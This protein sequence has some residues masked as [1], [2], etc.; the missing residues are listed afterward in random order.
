MIKQLLGH[1][2][3]FFQILLL[4]FSKKS[5]TIKHH[6]VSTRRD[7][8]S[9]FYVKFVPLLNKSLIFFV[10]I[11]LLVNQQQK[12]PLFFNCSLH[13]LKWGSNLSCLIRSN[14]L[15][16]NS[17]FK[18]LKWSLPKFLT[19]NLIKNLKIEN[20]YFKIEFACFLCDRMWFIIY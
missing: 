13:F 18:Y 12:C 20:I 4:H 14:T 16:S 10:N 2:P 11:F 6:I 15:V 8:I 17:L 9:R 1:T 3:Y 7:N 19:E 5:V